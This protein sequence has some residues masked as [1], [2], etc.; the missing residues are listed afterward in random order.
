MPTL[1]DKIDFF[2]R[3]C[4]AFAGSHERRLADLNIVKLQVSVDRQEYIV[5]WSNTNDKRNTRINAIGS[6]DNRSGFVFGMHLNIDTEA[7][8]EDVEDAAKRCGDME[9]DPAFRE[10]A[11]FW[12]DKDYEVLS[13]QKLEFV[14]SG[15]AEVIPAIAES[16]AE[17]SYRADVEAFEQMNATVR[18][19]KAGMLIHGEYTMYGHFM[20]LRKLLPKA[21]KIRFYM[22]KESG[23]RAACFAAFHDDIRS[24]RCNAFYLK[25][26]KEMTINQKNVAM[27]H[28]QRDLEDF[29]GNSKYY[30]DVSDNSLRALMFDN[31]ISAGDYFLSTPYKDKWYLYPAPPKNEPEKA[32]SWLTDLGDRH[33]RSFHVALLMLRASLHGIDRF[34]M[35]VRRRI[36][37]LERPIKT[38]SSTGRT[39]YGYSPYNPAHVVKLLEIFRVYHNYVHATANV[40]RRILKKDEKKRNPGEVQK[41]MITPAMRLRLVERKYEVADIL[42]FR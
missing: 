25:I 6:A 19:P 35:Q 17:L 5:N 26:N 36:S 1:Y 28:A 39:W 3:Q 24:W 40:K 8:K 31:A 12:L 18:L 20:L 9:K 41:T 22:E 32:V 13:R 29:R 42:A 15:K 2:Y 7:K 38:S 27:A 23:I 16:D 33:Y 11:R 4:L 34:F 21:T 37:L 30:Q 10:H 14:P